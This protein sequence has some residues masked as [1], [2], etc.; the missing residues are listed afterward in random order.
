MAQ[1][2]NVQVTNTNTGT[3][4]TTGQHA[5]VHGNGVFCNV[6]GVQ[7]PAGFLNN[8]GHNFVITGNDLATGATYNS[9]NMNPDDANSDPPRIIAFA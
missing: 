5:T 8:P 9:G 6:G 4:W 1:I 7:P 2:V 3:V